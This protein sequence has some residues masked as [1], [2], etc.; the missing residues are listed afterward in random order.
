MLVI[1]VLGIISELLSF[2]HAS[3]QVW[4]VILNGEK[5]KERGI[6]GERQSTVAKGQGLS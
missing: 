5:D 3:T 1:L 2:S 4:G 6:L